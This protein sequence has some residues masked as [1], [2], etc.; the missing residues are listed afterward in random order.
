[1]TAQSKLFIVATPIGNLDDFSL[2]AIEVLKAVDL[3]A[4]EDTR[5]S[6]KL[7]QHYQIDTPMVSYHDF[8]DLTETL[9]LIELLQAGKS[10]ALISDAGTPLISDPGYRLVSEAR[11]ADIPVLPIPGASA[12]TAALSVSGLPTDRFSFEG[13]LPAKQVARVKKLQ[14]LELDSRTL[15]FYESPHRIQASLADMT[16]VFGE[17]RKTFV[18][19]ELTKKFESHFLGDLQ[20]CL[21]WVEADA[22]NQK[23]EFVIVVAGNDDDKDEDSKLQQAMAIVHTLSADLSMKRAVALASEITGTRKNLL[24]DKALKEMDSI[25]E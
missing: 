8:S 19:R 20:Q 3:V 1:M 16:A 13:F 17:S 22:N 9:K 10:I 12:L 11:S 23:G 15:V 24:Y 25:A 6:K 7:L 2:R 5:H 18:G 4:A 21:Q 14:L